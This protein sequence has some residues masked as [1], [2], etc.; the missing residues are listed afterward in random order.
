MT[1]MH[2][3]F[4]RRA[5]AATALSLLAGATAHAA[6]VKPIRVIIVGDSTMASKSGYGD[7]LCAR[8][9][10]QAKCVNLARGGRSSSSFRAEGLWDGVT[11]LLRDGGS[12][13]S[14]TYVLVQFG[15]N[16]QPGK[17]ERA[18][19]L[20][21][22][23]PANM[24]RYAREVKELG[25]VPVL[26]TPLTRRSFVGAYV[27]DDLGP[28]AEATRRTAKTEKVALIDLNRIS[29]DAVQAMGQDEADTLATAPR[30]A[31][32]KTSPSGDRA[33]E[34]PPGEPKSSFDRTHLG[35]K[36]AQVFSALVAV[37]LARLFPDVKASLK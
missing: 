32:F 8:L 17:G 6:D 2:N 3:T 34:P 27:K 36:G 16:D 31:W 11:K 30:P 18:T 33:P 10:E 19:D 7:A 29:T 22:Q 20:V 28:W 24:A 14:H 5:L 12:D 9:V 35:A 13:Y 37:E 1:T 21:T 26:V 23:F 15:H 4:L 25:G